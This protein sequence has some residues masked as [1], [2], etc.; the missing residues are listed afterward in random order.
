VRGGMN[1]HNAHT[2][3]AA[4]AHSGRPARKEV[5][6]GHDTTNNNNDNNNKMIS[7]GVNTS[8]E[9]T[10]TTTTVVA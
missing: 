6:D 2:I 5:E 10:T 7:R 9:R 8:G 4:A 3:G 1:K